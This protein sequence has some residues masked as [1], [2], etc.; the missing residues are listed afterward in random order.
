MAWETVDGKLQKV[1][2]KKDFAEALAYVNAVGEKAEAANH[3]PD[4]A[5][6]WNTVTLT[7]WTHDAGKVTEADV[8]MARTLDVLD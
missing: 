7:L 5:I 8:A 6:S 4:I 3:H 1:V 2:K